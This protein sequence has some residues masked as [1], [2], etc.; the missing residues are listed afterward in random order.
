M[1]VAISRYN[2]DHSPLGLGMRNGGFFFLFLVVGEAG[3][4]DGGCNE[5]GACYQAQG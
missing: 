1:P 3:D 2:M 5:D 4:E